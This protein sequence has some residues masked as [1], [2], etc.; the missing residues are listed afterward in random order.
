VSYKVEV[1]SNNLTPILDTFA[2]QPAFRP[3]LPIVYGPLEFRQQRELFQRLDELIEQGGFEREFISL[4]MSLRPGNWAKASGAAKERF[5][6]YSV[7]ALRCNIAR[8]ITGLNFRDMAIRTADSTLLQWFLRIGEIE[9]VKSPSKSSVERFS[10]WV[11]LKS[12]EKLCDRLLM[13][14]AQG[15]SQEQ[16][17]PLKLAQPMELSEAFLDA[18]CA[19][20][21]MHFPNDWVLLRDAA[22]TLMKATLLI[23][24]AGL[25][26]RMPQEPLAFLSQMNKLS[27]AMSAQRRRKDSKKKRKALLRQMKALEHKIAR[28]ARAHRDVLE[29]NHEQSL[30]RPGQARVII[31]RIDNVLEQLPAAIWQAHERIIGER[32]VPNDQKI[33]SLYESEVCV[34]VRGK[35]GAE[36]EFGNQ[37]W[38]AESRA[39]LILD[40]KLLKD[41]S[42]DAKLLQPGIERLIGERGLSITK[43]WGDRGLFSKANEEYLQKQG[44]Q[45]GLCPRR[46]QELKRRLGEEEGFGEGLR[47]R[48]G[49]EARIGIFKNVFMGSPLKAK[50]FEHQE[51]EVGWAALA[52]NLWVVARRAKDELRT[53]PGPVPEDDPMLKRVRRPNSERTRARRAA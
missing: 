35:V 23:R 41:A 26:V 13:L 43:A 51:L 27:I 10:K 1:S 12:V 52:H 3:A 14:C 18:T 50:G 36:V 11:N 31:A 20:V 53:H 6:R 15:A 25:K 44:I 30:L 9:R 22:R 4:A 28:H 7:L 17:Q 34:V 47:R 5:A 37:L 8:K 29:Q 33:L 46:V 24:Q 2:Y 42:G 16:P 45:S 38:L 39:G 49:T 32:P 40:W 48:G 19:R 21:H